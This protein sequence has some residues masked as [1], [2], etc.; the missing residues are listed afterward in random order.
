MKNLY[1]DLE[2][3]GWKGK[4]VK[5]TKKRP[6]CQEESAFGIVPELS[7]VARKESGQRDNMLWS[8]SEP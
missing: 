8:L 1:P 6:K 2:V 5:T 3:N 4:L 7:D